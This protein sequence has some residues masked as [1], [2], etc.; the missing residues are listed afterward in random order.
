MKA[1]L[2]AR[3]VAALT[4]PAGKDEETFWDIELRGFGF[5]I[6]RHGNGT[7]K[8]WLAQW[9]RGGKTSKVTLGKAPPLGAEAAREAARKILA[10][11]AL[12]EDPQR[13]RREQRDQD[14][15]TMGA[16]VPKYLE[17]KEPGLRPATFDEVKRYLTG[18]YFRPLHKKAIDSIRRGDVS[19]RVAAIERESGAPAAS[20]ARTVFHGFYVWCM[21]MGHTTTD[22]NPVANSYRPADSKPRDR[23]LSDA[24]LARI[25]NAC[26]DG[27]EHS[28]I[29]RLLILSGC[30]RQEIGGLR[31]WSE[32]DFERGTLTISASR[33]KN[34]RQ[35]VLPLMSAMRSILE[36][37]LRMASRDC[38]FGAR[39]AAGFTSWALS[40]PDLD[41]RSGIS[42]AWTLHD[43]RRSVATGM[44]NIGIQPHIIEQIL[45]HQ[46]GHKRGPAGIYNLSSYADQVR[47]A[48]GAWERY[49]ALL[50][51]RD[52]YTAH[53]RFL[54]SGDEETRDKAGK[55]FR[56]AIARGGGYWA[57]YLRVVR[58]GERK[59]VTFPQAAPA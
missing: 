39:A 33:S 14:R 58:D 40:K 27:S 9:K 4:L 59:V 3:N 21:R 35:H 41:R 53:A 18:P 44:A 2:T 48:L 20:A 1:K 23:V 12:G 16:L 8:T 5:R 36:S 38:V 30:R 49:I 55:T 7:V 6:R 46:S 26:D 13:E 22:A 31:W 47:G 57:D 45:N 54:T 56:E 50:V 37:C 19:E 17:A 24:E 32:V 51:D 29:V 42:T 34:H 11:V 43:L 25:W 10:R 28:K 15:R 52:L